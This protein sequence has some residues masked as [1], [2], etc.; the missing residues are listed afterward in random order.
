MFSIFKITFLVD[1]KEKKIPRLIIIASKILNNSSK[2]WMTLKLQIVV[3]SV[4]ATCVCGR[5]VIMTQV[6][7]HRKLVHTL[8]ED[9]KLLQHFLRRCLVF[10]KLVHASTYTLSANT[11]VDVQQA[12]SSE[13][14]P[15]SYICPVL[16]A[17][18]WVSSKQIS[19]SPIYV[20]LPFST[21]MNSNM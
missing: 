9:T 2:F 6:H 7:T 17:P 21:W 15:S 18:L 8:F 14:L 1:N 19:K 11:L 4:A 3:P 20:V 16:E 5:A 10:W 12:N 13:A